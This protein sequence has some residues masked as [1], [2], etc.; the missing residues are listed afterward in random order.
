LVVGRYAA[1]FIFPGKN[2]TELIFT[3]QTLLGKLTF[4]LPHP[5]PANKKWLKNHPEFKR[6]RLKEVRLA[7]HDAIKSLT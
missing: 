6:K 3:N 1:N 5:S 4:V 7:I 2:F